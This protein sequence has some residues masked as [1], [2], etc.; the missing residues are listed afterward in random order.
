MILFNE[1][2][3][4]NYN[5]WERNYWP[6]RA[7]QIPMIG[8]MDVRN[9]DMTK[10]MKIA[11]KVLVWRQNASLHDVSKHVDPIFL[12]Q[13]NSFAPRIN[14]RSRVNRFVDTIT[15]SFQILDVEV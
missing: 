2:L 14:Y 13:W 8:I 12:G 10:V 11:V 1:S 15:P 4:T 7:Y 9:G 3:I 5:G 6:K